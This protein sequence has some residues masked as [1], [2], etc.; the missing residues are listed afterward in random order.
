[1]E[2]E[3]L[4]LCVASGVSAVAMIVI[5]VSDVTFRYWAKG[6]LSPK[7]RLMNSFV[8]FSKKAKGP[9]VV[10]V[11]LANSGEVP[12]QL[13]AAVAELTPEDKTTKASGKQSYGILV[14]ESIPSRATVDINIYIPRDHFPLSLEW[15]SPHWKYVH[16]K[17]KYISGS[18][19][20]E[21][22]F[23]NVARI[24][25]MDGDI[26]QCNDYYELRQEFH[27]QRWRAFCRRDR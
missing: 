20:G 25:R 2:I 22:Y 13:K 7:P 9:V 15:N 8:R 12:I 26:L 10:K 1:M 21:V 17:M 11:R 16:L 23:R 3:T 5:A 24:A 14:P 18:R 27:R 19:F 4:V 6:Q